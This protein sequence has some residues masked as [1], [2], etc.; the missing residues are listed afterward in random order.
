MTN[1][2]W[3]SVIQCTGI[4]LYMTLNSFFCN[5]KLTALFLFQKSWSR[6]GEE[7]SKAGQLVF[8]AAPKSSMLALI[9]SE[10]I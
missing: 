3:V 8:F 7:E 6:R 5:S 4:Y 9:Q 10:H 1:F 2:V